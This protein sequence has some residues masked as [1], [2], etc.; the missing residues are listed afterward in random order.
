MAPWPLPQ[1]YQQG[2]STIWL[3]PDLQYQFRSV[4]VS[5][6]EFTNC[7]SGQHVLQFAFQSPTLYFDLLI[8]RSMQRLSHSTQNQEASF[9]HR[10]N[11]TFRFRAAKG[12]YLFRTVSCLSNS[13]RRT[14]YSSRA[15]MNRESTLSRSLLNSSNAPTSERTRRIYHLKLIHLKL[16][17]MASL[18]SRLF[19]TMV[20][21]TLSTHSRS[22][23]THIAAVRMRFIL[24]MRQLSSR[25]GRYLG[26]EVS[27]WIL[28]GTASHPRMLSARLR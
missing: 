24:H 5:V 15:E 27:T 10:S 18:R 28:R 9:L 13:T 21:C 16:P 23:S 1:E 6:P 2:S 11:F 25:I 14:P 12:Y 4:H 19:H 17:K 8:E 20:V 7:W 22:C 3:S 26:T